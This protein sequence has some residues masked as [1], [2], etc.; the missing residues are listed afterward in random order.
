MKHCWIAGLALAIFP[1]S[2][3]GQIQPRCPNGTHIEGD[4]Q[5]TYA[6]VEDVA[7]TTKSPG[8]VGVVNNADD[9][10]HER[11]Q[12]QQLQKIAQ[13]CRGATLPSEAPQREIFNPA[14]T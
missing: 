4:V 8:L 13:M 14:I 9:V 10:Q 1:L 5:R 11:L 7:S 12:S 3:A 2:A 6:C